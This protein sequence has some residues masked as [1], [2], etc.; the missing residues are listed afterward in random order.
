[1]D[2]GA[3]WATVHGVAESGTTEATDTYLLTFLP[4]PASYTSRSSWSTKLSSLHYTAI[5]YQLSILH[6][7]I[8]VCQCYS[9]NFPFI[10]TL[11]KLYEIKK[12][13]FLRASVSSSVRWGN[14]IGPFLRSHSARIL[15]ILFPDILIYIQNYIFKTSRS[16]GF[17][18]E[19]Q[20][21]DFVFDLDFALF[22]VP[23]AG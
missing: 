15:S 11:T 4:T 12:V 13:R 2:R 17:S 16:S 7:V 8:Y 19:L 18:L 3:W 23:K 1:M 9:L 10:F 20:K 5:S 14:W 22:Y 21:P 6:V